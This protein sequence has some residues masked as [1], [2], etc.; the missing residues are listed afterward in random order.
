LRA[1]SLQYIIEGLKPSKLS[2]S[3]IKFS[4]SVV[5]GLLS[6]FEDG[7]KMGGSAFWFVGAGCEIVGEVWEGVVP[8]NGF[9]TSF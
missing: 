6:V 9:D 2:V 8:S 4:C 5:T 1:L 3:N 7:W